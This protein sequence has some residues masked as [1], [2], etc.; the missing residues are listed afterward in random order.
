MAKTEPDLFKTIHRIHIVSTQ[1]ANDILA[2]AYHSAFKGRG[3]EFEDVREYQPGDEIRSID[4]NV[5]ARMNHPY[6]KNFREERDITVILVVDVSASSLFGGQHVLKKEM[7]AE[8]GAVLAFSAIKNNDKVGLL[9]FSDII[10]K[11][12]P[13]RKGIRHV[14]RI[15]RDLLAFQPKKTGTDLKNALSYL[16]KVQRKSGIC[17]LISDFIAKDYSHEI[18]LIA[19]RHDL[20]SICVTDSYEHDF[21]K[22]GIVHLQDLESDETT[23]SNTNTEKLQ[24]RFQ[25]D[26]KKRMELHEHTMKQAGAGFIKIR[27]DE[28]YFDALRKFFKLREV[29]RK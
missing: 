22:K 6:V 14:L 18:A 23:I 2:G 1:L 20:I 11:Y 26:A 25:E 5:T 10:E 24:K 29:Q 27:T 3:I 9:L 16:G 8:I 13:P 12:I 19:K 28:S 4:W 17:F 15:I 21:P 7:I